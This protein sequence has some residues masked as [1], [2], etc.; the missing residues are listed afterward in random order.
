[1]KTLQRFLQLL[2][3]LLR[4]L[5]TLNVFYTILFLRSLDSN[6]FL[7]WKLYGI[8]VQLILIIF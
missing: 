7:F 3:Y 8:V 1:M 5:G 6:D 4:A 2:I